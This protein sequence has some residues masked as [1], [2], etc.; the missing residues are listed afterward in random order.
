MIQTMKVINA[1]EMGR[2]EK[3]AYAQGASEEFF[4]QQAGA[5]VAGAVQSYIARFHLRP[6]IVLLC[7]RGN[8]AG[9][10]YVAGTILKEGGFS[11]KALATHPKEECS[12][13]CQKMYTRFTKA[14]GVFIESDEIDFGEANILIDGLLGTGFHGDVEG[15]LREIIEA[16]NHS[17]L[18]II[19]V[20]IPSG[21][22][23]T[24][25]EVAS[26][27]IR[28]QETV[29]LGL[30]KTGCFLGEAWNHVGRV[31]VHNF[32]LKSEFS[33]QADADFTLIDEPKLPPVVRNRHK[34]EAG[35]VVGIG[36]SPGMPGAPIMSSYAALRVGAGIVRLLH[37]AGMEAEFAGAP[38]EVIRQGYKDHKE[39]IAALEKA[40]AVFIGPG[41]GKDSATRKLLKKVLPEIS[42][43]C[44]M[45]AEAL[46]ADL[47]FPKLAVLT[48]HRGEMARLLGSSDDLLN[49]SQAFAEKHNV[50]IVLKGAP[51]F[52]L[53]PGQ[54][55]ALC[56]RGDPGMATAGSGD[57]LTGMIAGIIAQVHDPLEAAIVG[58]QLHAMAGEHAAEEL[59]SY[60]MTATDLISALPLAIQDTIQ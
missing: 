46:D 54:K 28:A 49:Q 1:A 59:T 39:I 3:L 32:G 44:V 31:I 24:T 52:V 50:T 30:P 9:D 17:N 40:A 35:Y 10:A 41:I 8:N 36:G 22:N 13:L 16:A 6:D 57:V 43:P 37:P 34:Y 18:P 27:A 38:Y 56:V 4:M 26:G 48:P 19:S 47:P 20:D 14:G 45:D 12:E 42:C 33:D 21:I 15:D 11:V 60:S 5:G 7:G 29:F 58:V 25:G 55:P 23:G 53:H 2:I 51:T